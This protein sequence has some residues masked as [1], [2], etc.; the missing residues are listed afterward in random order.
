MPLTKRDVVIVWDE[1]KNFC[2]AKWEKLQSVKVCM[3][4]AHTMTKELME[5]GTVISGGNVA[6]AANLVD[7]A[8]QKYSK[9]NKRV[10]MK[11]VGSYIR[12]L[13]FRSPG[14]KGRR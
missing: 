6:A 8:C 11:T 7:S 3:K 14:L 2:G 13:S 12:K 5:K 1:M 4:A 10:C 9:D